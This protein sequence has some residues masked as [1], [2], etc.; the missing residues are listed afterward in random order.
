MLQVHHFPVFSSWNGDVKRQLKADLISD[1]LRVSM[2]TFRPN[3]INPRLGQSAPVLLGVSWAPGQ[4]WHPVSASSS[5]N[6]AGAGECSGVS[7]ASKQALPSSKR[8]Q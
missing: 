3:Q 6:P 7:D 1:L 4:G 2:L 8:K 5:A